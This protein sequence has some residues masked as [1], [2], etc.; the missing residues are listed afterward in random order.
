MSFPG[1]GLPTL[2]AAETATLKAAGDYQDRARGAV[3]MLEGSPSDHVLAVE[4]G[5]VKITSVAANGATKLLAIRGPGQLVGDFGCIDGTA[6]SGTAVALTPVSAWKIPAER[7]LDLV[8]S[9]AGLCFAVLRM[10]VARVRESDAKLGEY[11]EY[12]AGDRVVRLLAQLA[13][14]CMGG[15]AGSGVTIPV[16]QTE[17]AGSAG[18]SRE[19]VS[20]T[21]TALTSR[22]I[23]RARRGRIV[24]PDVAALLR[25]A[26]RK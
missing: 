4:R 19:T 16:D 13:V 22:G 8:R 20:R 5:V 7:F 12:S 2:S 10:M 18:V 15:Q 3:L 25:E 21:I 24:V 9:D 26:E 14:N 17:L 11:G 1:A 23:A 6:R